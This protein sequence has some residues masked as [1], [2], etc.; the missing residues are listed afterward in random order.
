MPPLRHVYATHS[1]RTAAEILTYAHDCY[2]RDGSYAGAFGA[3]EAWLE[4]LIP[5]ANCAWCHREIRGVPVISANQRHYC[6]EAHRR[7]AAHVRNQN[8]E[9]E[10]RA[11]EG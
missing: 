9:R 2:A 3:V 5:V 8:I 7:A 6:N 11:Q 1:H 4:S 10:I